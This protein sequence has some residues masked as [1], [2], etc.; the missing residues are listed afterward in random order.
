MPAALINLRC[1]IYHQKCIESIGESKSDLEILTLVAK[2]LGINDKYNKGNT[3]DTWLRKI[4][5]TTSIPMTY[6]EFKEKG[7]YVWPTL[8]DYKPCKQIQPFYENPEKNPLQTPSGKIEI[9][10]QVLFKKYGAD[11]PEI[12]PVPHYI[13]EWEGRYTHPQVDKYPLQLLAPHPKIRMHGKYND[14]PW[15]QEIYKVRGPDG[16][17]YE[18]VIMNTEDAQARGL[19][20]GDIARVFNDRGQILC[21]VVTTQRLYRGVVR[22]AYG[23]WWD[24]LEMK[25]GAIDRGGNAN[26]LTPN[27]DMSKH[28]LGMAAN[29]CLL[30]IEK[31]DLEALA[32]QYPEGWAGKYRSWNKE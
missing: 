13:P 17:E 32:K 28:H 1:A 25:P 2:R 31:A 6:E 26:M 21:G 20:K 3:E 10:S 4:Y 18:P 15:L 8:D 19:K 30:E 5:A 11:D 24:M 23:S 27:K 29:S 9:F 12:P 16:Y 14:V 7:Y 22:I